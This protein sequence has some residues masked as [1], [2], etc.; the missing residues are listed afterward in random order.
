LSETIDASALATLL[1]TVGGDKEF[2]DELIVT[3][4]E[5]APGMLHEM[6]HAIVE[7]DADKLRL[8]SHSLKT[9]SAQFGAT[10]LFELCRDIEMQAKE[11][12]VAA[13]QVAEAQTEYANVRQALENL[14]EV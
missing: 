13:S 9:N 10:A 1:E 6:E 2:L 12:N 7:N 8:V 4:L 14:R 11:G 5:D 3:F